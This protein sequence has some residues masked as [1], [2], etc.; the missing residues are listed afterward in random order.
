LLR[1]SSSGFQLPRFYT[2]LPLEIV[3]KKDE[4][5][6]PGTNLKVVDVK[7]REEV[8][9]EVGEEV[10]TEAESIRVDSKLDTGGN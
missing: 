10:D 3:T 5:F 4:Y 2:S 9:V 6:A 8:A 1:C 7:V